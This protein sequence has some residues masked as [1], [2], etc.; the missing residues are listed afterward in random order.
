MWP[1]EI[2]D[3]LQNFK[4]PTEEIDLDL[5]DYSKLACNLVDI[6]THNTINNKNLIESLH[7][8]FTLYCEFKANQHFQ[9]KEEQSRYVEG[10]VNN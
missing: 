3:A 7:V 10:F 8:F 4:L 6:P 2:E 1:S 5:K 9:Q